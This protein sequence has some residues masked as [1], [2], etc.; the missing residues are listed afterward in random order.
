MLALDM[1]AV[2]T[3]A[4]GLS[5]VLAACHFALL[6]C[7]RCQALL[8]SLVLR[9]NT[10]SS[11]IKGLEGQFTEAA[12]NQSDLQRELETAEQHLTTDGKAF[13]RKTP[14]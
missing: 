2:L 9:L 11:E 12:H 14:C 4:A 6:T 3:H 8:K 10:P 1:F 5:S 13:S 7:C